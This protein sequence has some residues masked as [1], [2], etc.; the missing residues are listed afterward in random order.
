M[1]QVLRGCFEKWQHNIL[2]LN[3]DDKYSSPV[4][5]CL[6]EETSSRHISALSE[7]IQEKENGLKLSL[8]QIQKFGLHN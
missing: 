4:A 8:K 6:E 7:Y 2:F 1:G 5:F 3:A